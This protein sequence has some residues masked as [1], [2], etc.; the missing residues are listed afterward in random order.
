MFGVALLYGKNGSRF[1]QRAAQQFG[2]RKA[3]SLGLVGCRRGELG[4]VLKTWG[5]MAQEERIQV[6]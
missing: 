4:D 5:M 3:A 2:P 1:W 6:E